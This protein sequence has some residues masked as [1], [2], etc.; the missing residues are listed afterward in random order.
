MRSNLS[1]I[2]LLAVPGVVLSTLLVGSVVAWGAGLSLGIAFVFGALISATDAMAVV[3]IFR[4]LGAPR[5]LNV[6][7]EG[8]SLFNDGTA[9]VIFELALA[10]FITGEFNA[11]DGLF[12]FIRV[13]GGGII[14][15]L[16][17]GWLV[18]QLMARIDDHLIETSLTTCSPSVPFCWQR[19]SC[20]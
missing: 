11:L 5:R 19:S 18:T 16:A 17:L 7:L 3:A 14:S 4:K 20:K 1:T 15:G 6:L 9:I 8:E 13:A 2:A 10:A 12:D